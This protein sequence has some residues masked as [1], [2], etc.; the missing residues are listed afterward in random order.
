MRSRSEFRNRIPDGRGW[1][2]GEP[3]PS[4]QRDLGLN[5]AARQDRTRTDGVSV[6]YLERDDNHED[7]FV[8]IRKDVLDESPASANECDGD[9]QQRPLQTKTE[10]ISP[11]QVGL[12]GLSAG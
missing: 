1:G 10:N 8:F 11:T 4:S 5:P 6:A 3:T 7:L 2:L 9:E 12:F